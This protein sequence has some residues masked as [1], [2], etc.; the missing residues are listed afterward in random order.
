[1]TTYNLTASATITVI[2]N[3]EEHTINADVNF[4]FGDATTLK[5]LQ[6]LAEDAILEAWTEE[7]STPIDIDTDTIEIEITDFDEVPEHY[8]TAGTLDEDSN[9]WDFAA[10]TQECDQEPEVIAAALNLGIEPSDIDEAYQGSYT[11]DEDFAR[12]TAD[13]LGAVDEK[14]GWP[15]NCIDWEY[16]AKE[17]MYDYCEDNGHYFRNF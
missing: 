1:M 5:E 8:Q 9:F 7:H 14:A 3:D 6:T 2:V 4:D 12:E 13:Q 15:M 11:D 10:A 16:A 17:L